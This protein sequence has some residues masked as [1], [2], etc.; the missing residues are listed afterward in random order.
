MIAAFFF[1]PIATLAAASGPVAETGFNPFQ[2]GTSRHSP[3]R[4]MLSSI[5]ATADKQ[6]RRR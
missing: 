2:S 6:E 5:G 4:I 3:R 1:D